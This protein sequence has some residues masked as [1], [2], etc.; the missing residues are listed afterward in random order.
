MPARIPATRPALESKADRTARLATMIEDARARRRHID[1]HLVE[2]EGGPA[3][4]PP[5]GGGIHP[6]PEP[7]SDR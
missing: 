4:H 1:G 7:G 6:V 5:V 3:P 2:L